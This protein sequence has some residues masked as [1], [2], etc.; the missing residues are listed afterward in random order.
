MNIYSLYV[1]RSREEKKYFY[2]TIDFIGQNNF[3][4]NIQIV[5][6]DFKYTDSYENLI[7]NTKPFKAQVYQGAKLIKSV[8]IHNLSELI[9]LYSSPKNGKPNVFMYSGHSDGIYLRKKSLRLLRIEDFCTI[10]SSVLNKKADLIIYDCCLCGNINCLSVSYPYADD[11]IASSSYWS[12]MSVL[13]TY[14]LFK[15]TKPEHYKDIIKEIMHLEKTEKDVYVTDF[16]LYHMNEAFLEFAKMVLEYKNYFDL[17]KS[18]VIDQSYYKDI[19]CEF[20]DLGEIVTNFFNKFILFQRFHVRKC[21]NRK[22]SKKSDTSWPSGLLII[23]KRPMK[24]IPTKGDV[25]F[26]TTQKG[27]EP[28][29][30]R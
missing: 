8:I 10:I 18:Y 19:Q 12:Y 1:T 16:V 9:G 29:T 21:R 5:Y 14:S 3:D 22:I 30:Y 6:L 13:D 28:L 27:I 4:N 26:K 15:V 20:K 11:I 7:T 23:L 17:K 2:K 25:F 24:S